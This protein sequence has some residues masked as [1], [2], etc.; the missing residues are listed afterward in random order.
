MA[1]HFCYWLS[2]AKGRLFVVRAR[3]F[4]EEGRAITPALR[5]RA[6]AVE[7]ASRNH[8]LDG[9]RGCLAVVVLADHAFLSFGNEALM[10]PARLAVWGFFIMSA[11]V[12]TRA[13]DGAYLS[14]LVRR[15]VR[16]WP[17][18]AV[19]LTAA[20]AM[21][22]LPV[23]AW[24]YVWVPVNPPI[25]NS[26][27]WSLTVEMAAMFLMPAFVY[28]GRGSF[29]RLVIGLLA[30]LAVQLFLMPYAVFA[31]FF[32]I[33]AWL[34]RFE[35]RA[36]FLESRPVQWLGRISYPL[37]LCHVPIISWMGLPLAA[38]IPL[39]FATAAL[40]TVTVEKW[41]IRASRR[42]R[43]QPL[44]PMAEGALQSG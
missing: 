18:H 20:F 13:W 39:A 2:G 16:L 28:V 15:F 30:A 7:M 8:S 11:S 17:V 40:L 19:C 41:S 31:C 36:P 5:R 22:G 23:D 42:I 9:L 26:P 38:S 37:Y 34:S 33:G 12:L 4:V 24:Q 10:V 3:R 21:S 29:A 14:F 25:A 44:R 1:G 6:Y 27:I 32:F 43:F 35:L